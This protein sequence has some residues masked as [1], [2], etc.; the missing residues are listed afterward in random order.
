MGNLFKD[1]L[2]IYVGIYYALEVVFR[3]KGCLVIFSG[4]NIT[5]S[6]LVIKYKH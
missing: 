5:D 6:S 2:E 1:K 3:D 4:L